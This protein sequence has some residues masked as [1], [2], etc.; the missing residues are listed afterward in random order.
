MVISPEAEL[1]YLAMPHTSHARQIVDLI[2]GRF[3]TLIATVYRLACHFP[4]VLLQ[5]FCVVR[6]SD[7]S[8]MQNTL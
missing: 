2:V 1:L 6:R 4:F 3:K 5:R 8:S 7:P